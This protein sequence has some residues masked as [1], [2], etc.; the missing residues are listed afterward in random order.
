MIHEDQIF[1][2]DVVVTN[3]TQETMV[4]SVISQLIGESQNLRSL[5]RSTNMKGF[6][7]G[8]NLF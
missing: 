2:V 7:K 5:L 1:V 4:T 6:M 8:T 3:L